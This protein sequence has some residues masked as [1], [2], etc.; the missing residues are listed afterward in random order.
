M[1]R[2]CWGLISKLLNVGTYIL[3]GKGGVVSSPLYDLEGLCRTLDD[4][5]GIYACGFVGRTLPYKHCLLGK[6]WERTGINRYLHS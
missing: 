3:D 1:R 6:L 4:L 2:I 5:S